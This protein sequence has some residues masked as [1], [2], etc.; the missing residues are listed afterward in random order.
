MDLIFL[1]FHDASESERLRHYRRFYTTSCLVVC[2]I[3][4]QSLKSVQERVESDRQTRPSKPSR[5]NEYCA[6]AN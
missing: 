4:N 2:Q 3:G 6:E 5:I 1:L